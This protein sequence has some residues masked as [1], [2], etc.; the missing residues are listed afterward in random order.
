MTRLRL[1]GAWDMRDGRRRRRGPNPRRGG[2][3][4]RYTRGMLVSGWSAI[5]LTA[6]LVI[7][8]LVGY[9][10]YRDVLDGI[11]HIAVTDLG[12]RPPKL[13]NAMNILLIGSDS[14]SGRNGKIGGRV[15]L[16]QRSDT[17]MIV[18]ISP[19][20]SH[21]Y[22]LSFPRD[23]IVP[24]Y[25]CAPE[26]GFSGQTAQA[27]AVEQLN[28]SF[29]YGGPGCLWKTLEHTTNIRIDDFIELNF[30]GFIS[31]INALGGVEVCLPTAI[32]PS[33]YDHL[34]LSPGRH[35]LYGYKALEFWRLREDFGLGSDL[36]RIQRDQLLM[37][38]LV[39]R[40]LKSGVL[41]SLTKTYS[42]ISAIVRAHA[43]TT[44]TGLTPSKIL[45]IGS[46]LSGI[47]RKSVQFVEV[48]TVA[49][50]PNQNWVELDTTQDPKLFSAVAHDVRLPKVH[51]GRQAKNGKGSGGK[52]ST[53]PKLLTAS[54]VN[55]EVLNGSGVSGIAGATGTALTARGFH[56]VGAASA[57]TSTGAP[58]FSYVQSVVEY[59][60]TADLAAARTVAAQL[61]DVTL[62]LNTAV[63]AGQVT[64]ILGLTFKAL[65]A[66]HESQSQS[67]GNLAKQYSGYTGGTNVCKGY[68]TAF[69]GT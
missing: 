13:N 36:Q 1:G 62:Q 22:V 38:G 59:G 42:I 3:A 64:L 67:P 35:F 32:R 34:S 16:G 57:L 48:P 9:V 43:L 7:G 27:G 24:I 2:G 4:A 18:H 47:S 52:G 50:P 37:V 30:T 14:R 12:K 69:T 49:Y 39:Q 17:V 21:I 10:K 5:G 28:A 31:V 63:P 15:A 44:D 58:D 45:Q 19:G 60:S 8:T 33:S 20:H 56:V 66:P 11:K 54:K 61:R 6:V 46:S 65:A 29:A 25:S 51:K 26:P 41:H 68:G 40:I 53:A 55:V 23:T